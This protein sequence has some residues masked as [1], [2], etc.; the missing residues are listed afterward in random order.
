MAV[1]PPAHHERR[2][3]RR[4]GRGRGGRGDRLGSGPR[5]CRRGGGRPR[6][7]G[8]SAG[9][10]RLGDLA[11]GVAHRLG[12]GE[13]V[14]LLGVEEAGLQPQVVLQGAEGVLEERLEELALRAARVRGRRRGCPAGGRGAWRCPSRS[15][16]SSLAPSASRRSIDL[17]RPTGHGASDD[18]RAPRR[19]PGSP[20]RAARF[21]AR[22]RVAAR[23]VRARRSHGVRDLPPVADHEAEPV[24]RAR[25]AALKRS[26][27]MVWRLRVDHHR[28]ALV[29]GL[30][31]G[32]RPRLGDEQV[33]RG[34][35]VGDA[36]GEADG[37]RAGRPRV[38]GERLEPR[39]ERRVVAADR[40][41]LPR[42]ADRPQER[43]AR[44]SIS[45][46]PLPP[47]RSRTAKS[48]VRARRAPRGPARALPPAPSRVEARMQHHARDARDALG[49]DAEVDA[50]GA[51]PRPCPRSPAIEARLDP[52]ARREV[53]EVGEQ[54][55]EAARRGGSAPSAS[56][57][58]PLKFGITESTA[59]G[60][61]AARSGASSRT[62]AVRRRRD[63]G[64]AGRGAGGRAA[65]VQRRRRIR[66]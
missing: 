45:G 34:H 36:V 31:Q 39:Q 7:S 61:R 64:R 15:E 9:V 44:G 27:G 6:R 40:D 32:A 42:G 13:V 41:H 50:P 19:P 55:E 59:A 58:T 57:T 17:H 48:P 60:R 22:S 8:G 26:W 14:A 62:R 52:E 20:G 3:R 16:S 25:S 11:S 35:V 10:E 2:R 43:R 28:H 29:E 1:G 24:L 12:E 37:M 65:R 4:W 56:R 49:R 63:R 53:G 30:G 21:A 38:A 46:E 18:R 33:A 51:P 54:H 47:K 23:G 66:L 5:R